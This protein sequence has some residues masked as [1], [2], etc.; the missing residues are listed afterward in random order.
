MIVCDVGPRDGLQN[1][2]KTLDPGVRA[3]LCD[4][5]AAAGVKRM[6]AASFVNPKLVPQMAGAESVMEAL[7]R[8]PGTVYAGLVLNEKGYDRALAAGVDEVHYAFS[9]ADEFGRRNQNATTEEGLK[10]ALSLVAKARADRMP[11]TVTISVSF[12]SPF[13]GPVPA[14][15]VLKLVEALMTIPPDE[16]CLADTI[17][18]GVPSQVHELVRGARGLGAS[19]GAHFHNTRNTGYA[20]ATAALEEGVVSL[21]ASVGGAGGCPFAPNATGNIATE[22]LVYLLRGLGVEAGIDLDAL[23]ATSRWLGLQLGKELPGMLAR[24]GDYPY[25]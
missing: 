2:A 1:E 8:R 17:G 4:R 20:N 24:A 6:E 11:V 18:V 15:R 19:V 25:R 9:A 22:D 7:R 5:L 21:D 12:G 16:V 14:S 3:E 13:D 23:I 10:T